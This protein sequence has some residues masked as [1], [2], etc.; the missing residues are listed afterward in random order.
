MLK[1]VRPVHIHTIHTELRTRR[2]RESAPYLT[3][4]FSLG[5]V[6]SQ[7]R[8][9]TESPGGLQLCSEC[10]YFLKEGICSCIAYVIKITFQKELGEISFS[11]AA[12]TNY[13]KLSDL[14]QHKLFTLQSGRP[15]FNIG[16][17]GYSQGVGRLCSFWKL[18]GKICFLA[19]SKLQRLSTY[20]G[21]WPLPSPTSQQHW[22][23]SFSNG[24]ISLVLSLLPPSSILRVL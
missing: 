24:H 23:E 15:K 8:A 5:G 10:L 21:L 11:M 7:E 4:S 1:A 22:A 2:P 13:L 6:G 16:L 17:M 19:F 12:I 9:R 20:L 18:Q 3:Q 14:K